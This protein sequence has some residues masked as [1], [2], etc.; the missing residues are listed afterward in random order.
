MAAKMKVRVKVSIQNG[1]R[2]KWLPAGSVVELDKVD[3]LNLIANEQA[4]ALDTGMDIPSEQTAPAA[5]VAPAA[6]GDS[7]DDTAEQR[8]ACIDELLQ[9]KGITDKN[10]NA[11]YDAGFTSVAALQKATAAQLKAVPDI[12]LRVAQMIVRDAAEFETE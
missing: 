5:Q 6:E 10:V 9:V 4:T 8:A 1:A 7:S 3:A 11:I 12:T 2:T